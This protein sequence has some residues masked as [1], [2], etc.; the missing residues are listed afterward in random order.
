MTRKADMTSRDPIVSDQENDPRDAHEP[1]NE[2]NG[3]LMRRN[4]EFTPA[5]KIKGLKLV[6]NRLNEPL[7][8]ED[9]GTTDRDDI[10][11]DVGPV[12]NQYVRCKH[13][14]TT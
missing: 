14:C 6:I 13:I 2:P 5:L 1:V 8:E 10:D 11:R 3:L 12:E 4:G 9:K 7:I